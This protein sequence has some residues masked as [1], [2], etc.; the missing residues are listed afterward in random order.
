MAQKEAVRQFKKGLISEAC[1][2]LFCER[3]YEAVTVQ[4]IADAAGMGKATLYQYF[5]SKEEILFSLLRRSSDEINRMIEAC[6]DKGQ[7]PYI[8][9]KEVISLTYRQYLENNRIFLTYLALKRNAAFK[10]EWVGELHALRDRKFELL[11]TV[12]EKGT[13]QGVFIQ[14]DSRRFAR[15]LNNILRGFSLEPLETWQGEPIRE[16]GEEIIQSIIF[17]GILAD[18]GGLT[19]E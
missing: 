11:A 13:K 14:V 18:G 6:C 2:Q 17:K 16:L 4:D 15:V 19:S 7:D 8:T 1:H 5:E 3:C 10:R 12:L 9:L